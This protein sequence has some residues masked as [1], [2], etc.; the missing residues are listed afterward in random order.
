MQFNGLLTGY[1]ERLGQGEVRAQG[2]DGLACSRKETGV[3]ASGEGM[4]APAEGGRWPKGLAEDA[5]G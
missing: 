1:R 4:R 2:S 3:G 5:T